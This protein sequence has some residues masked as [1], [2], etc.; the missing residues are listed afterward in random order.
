MGIHLW[1][2]EVL[3]VYSLILLPLFMYL[4]SKTG[5]ALLTRT[6]AALRMPGF[7]LLLAAPIAIM[8]YVTNIP[9]IR[10]TPLGTKAFGGWSLLPYVVFFT[11]GYIVAAEGRFGAI[12]EKQRTIG[13]AAGAAVTSMA[14][15][16]IGAGYSVP[17]WLV[18]VLRAVN[19]WAWLVAI[20]GFGSRY[21][22]FS[23]GF[24]KYANE[25]VLPVYILHQ[26]VMLAAGFYITRL[27]TAIGTKF[28]VIAAMSLLV[29]IGLYELLIRRANTLRFLF[30]MKTLP[31]ACGTT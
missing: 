18:A 7:I 24:L 19:A 30:G 2:L 12:I 10:D 14:F 3:F 4:R 22:N 20:L 26:T 11:I 27:D 15:Y 8:E 5:V 23:N 17:D 31:T 1:Y 29:I 25:A 9:S 21:L 16:M 6:A 13:L 28:V